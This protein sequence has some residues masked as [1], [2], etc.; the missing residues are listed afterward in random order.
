VGASPFLEPIDHSESCIGQVEQM[1]E[2]TQRTVSQKVPADVDPIARD[3][4]RRLAEVHGPCVSVYLPTTRF[5]PE[6]L[7]GPTRLGHL[8]DHADQELQAGGASRSQVHD[9]LA[10]LRA[11]LRDDAFWQHQGRGLALFAAPEVFAEY[12]TSAPLTEHVTVGEHFRIG[13]LVRELGHEGVFF[14]LAISQNVVR[15]F[16]ATGKTI[17]ELPLGDIPASMEEAIPQEVPEFYDQSH[18]I[19]PG[20]QLFHGHGSEADYDKA[21]LERFLRAV[22]H[23]LVHRLGGQTHPL[24]LACVGYYVAVYKAVSHYPMVWPDAVEGNPDRRSVAELHDAA[25]A[26]VADHFAEPARRRLDRYRQAAGTGLAL[27]RPEEVLAAARSGKVDT[28]LL[29]AET[30]GTVDDRVEEALVETL[31]HNGD[32]VAVEEG[33]GLEGGAGALLRY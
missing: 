31:R 19:G 3:E 6:T 28:L 14:I 5:G 23:P 4:L 20:I 11:L 18:S 1:R 27:S 30:P 33:A 16:E 15:L 29:G 8:I 21:A 2:N 13:P 32:I 9:V 24:V 10:P 7:S 25:W 26:L 12:R 17:R 22:D